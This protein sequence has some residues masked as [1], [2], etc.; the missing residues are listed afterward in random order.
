MIAI[1]LGAFA[2]LRPNKRKGLVAASLVALALSLAPEFLNIESA[3]DGFIY[4]LTPLSAS[5]PCLLF[6]VFAF[7]EDEALT[8]RKM[9]LPYGILLCTSLVYTALQHATHLQPV[10]N[11]RST[12]SFKAYDYLRQ[13]PPADYQLYVFGNSGDI[14][15]YNEFHILAPSKWIYHHF[16]TWYPRWDADQAILRS[17]G[18]DLLR[19]RTAYVLMK[20]ADLTEFCN[21]ANRQW[22]L[23]FMQTYYQ[24]L[25]VPGSTGTILWGLKK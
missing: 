12:A 17:I 1:V 19:H 25:A 18:Q 8:H 3:K 24:P 13:H 10:A 22:W 6:T 20:Q 15:A 9:Q 21:P 2:L 11:N 4:Y 14:D 7:S 23:S 5:I 16:W